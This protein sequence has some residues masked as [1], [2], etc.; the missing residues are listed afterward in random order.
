[1]KAILKALLTSLGIKRFLAAVV[2]TILAIVVTIPGAA[3]IIPILTA[4]AAALG[5]TGLAHATG[6]GTLNG[7]NPANIASVI[8]FLL[9][10][11]RQ[12]PQL[13]FLIPI[14]EILAAIF[15]GATISNGLKAVV[16]KVK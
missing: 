16:A 3:P 14:L 2:S 1:M 13:A 5:V 4:L 10:V 6:A 8:A 12:I 11:C 15:G 9:L 7:L